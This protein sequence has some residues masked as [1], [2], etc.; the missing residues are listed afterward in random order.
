MTPPGNSSIE[1]TQSESALDQQT[2][3]FLQIAQDFA[4]LEGWDQT[5]AAAV[6]SVR[7]LTGAQGSNIV[8]KEG[9]KVFYAEEE[10]VE[11]LWKGKR[12]AANSSIAGW[13]ILN[14][15][16]AIIE[17]VLGDTRV[18]PDFYRE[19]FVKSLIM[20]PIRRE[21]PIGVIGA[22]WNCARAPAPR[23][24]ALLEWLAELTAIAFASAS[25][26]EEL[27]RAVRE[28]SQA[29]ERLRESEARFHA[30][31]E[32]IEKY[33]IYMLDTEGRVTSW[34]AGAEQIKGYKAEEILGRHFGCFFPEEAVREGEPERS[35]RTAAAQG[36]CEAQ[37][38]LIRK[39]GARFWAETVLTAL[40][41]QSGQVYGFSKVTRDMTRQKWEGQRFQAAV[42]SAPNAMVMINDKGQIV[43]I[44]AQGEKLFGYAREELLGKSIELLVPERFRGAHP[45]YRKD[46]FHE[47]RSRAMGAG[48][49][50]FGRCKDGSEIPVEIGLN[51]IQTDEGKFVLAAIVDISE[52][53]RAEERFR[54]AVEAAP[55]AMV[56]INPEGSIILVNA[57]TEKLFGYSRE[58]L[59]GTT[60]EMLVPERF[61][62][63]HPAYRKDFFA[64][65]RSRAMGAGRDLYGLKKDGAEIPVEIGLNPFTTE[66]GTFVLAAIVDITERKRAEEALKKTAE[67]LA[68][69]NTELQQFAYVASHDL[70]EPLRAVA[71]CVDLLRQRY[72]G[73][74]EGPADQLMEHAV[75]GAMRMQTL[76]SDLLAYSRLDTRGGSFQLFDSGNAFQAA[77]SNLQVS[78]EERNAQITHDPLPTVF[79]DETQLTQLF[80]NLIGNA[81]K[82]HG[83]RPLTVHTS[84]ERRVNEWVFSV[85]DNGIGIE[86]DYYDRIFQIFQRLHTQREYPGTGIGLA[87]CKKIVDRHGG[88]MWVKSAPGVGS[89]FYFT[90]PI[91]R[92]TYA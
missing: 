57:Q 90:L 81:L 78:I 75:D 1:P 66:E 56:M 31:V 69:S 89:T 87:V 84:V 19:T 34:N 4:R 74:F 3:L 82:F 67:D 22:Y 72:E 47:P 23:E 43:L 52:R 65:P 35:L 62:Q 77:L 63:Q 51:P 53:K 11:P 46:F 15:R 86:P 8:I 33:A 10:A 41:D 5:M 54:V 85:S 91:E 79:A 68:R 32:T 25:R 45:N 92:I 40:R 49:D 20:V 64:C 30:L 42:E 12:F 27:R 60:I 59:L 21:D 37:G 83:E 76:I 24:I 16:T 71:G 58:E 2:R 6:Q 80:Q 38:W 61:R 50:L 29:E 73:R 14:R 13:A 88:R 9:E 70:Q 55:N 36:R 44:N 17:D 18:Q 48:R 7:K 28:H 39:D 26:M